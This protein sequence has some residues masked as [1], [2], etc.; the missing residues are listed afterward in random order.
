M[1]AAGVAINWFLDCS[2]AIARHPKF[3]RHDFGNASSF[4]RAS[5]TENSWTTQSEFD[6]DIEQ[7][8]SG[9]LPAPPMAHRVRGHIRKL[10]DGLPSDEARDN[11]PPYIRRHMSPNETWVRGHSRGGDVMGQHLLTRLQMFSSLADFL[12]TA[13][14]T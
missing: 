8:I 13:Q 1:F 7:I 5:E 9:Q 2:I 12:A 6:S 10:G 11:A 4:A 14:R 3:K